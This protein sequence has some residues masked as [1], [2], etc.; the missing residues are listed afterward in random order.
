[1]QTRITARHTE[2]SDGL[3][4]HIES[5]LNKLDRYYDGIYDA[6]VV[7]DGHAT[8]TTGKKAEVKVHL[9]RRTLTA[10]DAGVT[11]QDAVNGCVRQ[12]RRQVLRYKGKI[13]STDKDVHK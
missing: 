9:Y 11:Y 10:Q 2:L 3:R 13:R 8:T 4:A 7:L 1:M 5:S 12:L 6:H